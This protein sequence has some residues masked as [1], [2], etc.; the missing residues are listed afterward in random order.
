MKHSLYKTKKPLVRSPAVVSLIFSFAS[1]F[2]LLSRI[3]SSC[4][5]SSS[6]SSS[7]IYLNCGRISRSCVLSCFLPHD[8]KEIAAI[9]TNI[10][11]N[12]FI[13]FAFLKSVKQSFVLL[14]D[15]KVSIFLIRC[16]FF[17][18]FFLGVF[19]TKLQIAINQLLTKC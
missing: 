1:N 8:A 12:F 2:K 9:A 13:F 17:C 18:D 19:V 10:K 3:S 14:N 11:T 16:S 6:V 7:C 5:S 4:I 15:A